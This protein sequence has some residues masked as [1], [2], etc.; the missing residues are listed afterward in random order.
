MINDKIVAW[1]VAQKSP[2]SELRGHVTVT[3][4][5]GI[6]I[7]IIHNYIMHNVACGLMKLNPVTFKQNIPLVPQY[8]HLVTTIWSATILHCIKNRW[9]PED[10]NCH[11]TILYMCMMSHSKIVMRGLQL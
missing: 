7:Q 9:L 2:F 11:R 1:E 10:L 5:S 6:T 3:F 4:D 8:P